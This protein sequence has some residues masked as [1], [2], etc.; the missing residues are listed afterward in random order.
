[1]VAIE[2]FAGAD[3]GDERLT[4][5]LLRIVEGLAPKP[6]ASLPDAAKDDAELEGT[7]RF[8]QNEKVTP[9]GIL[10]PHYA[11]TARR[12]HEAGVVL[13]AH[14]TTEFSYSTEREGMGRINDG[15]RGFFA[16]IAL[17]IQADEARSP[18]GV[19]GLLTHVRRGTPR[20]DK[21][22]D[23]VAPKE[24]E[25][26]RWTE[27]VDAVEGRLQGHAEAVHLL[28]S[29]ADAY[30]LLE[31]MI[32]DGVRFVVR[33][34]HK[35]AVTPAAGGDRLPLSDTLAFL[36]G[37][38]ERRVLLSSRVAPP[39]RPRNRNQARDARLAH[40]S[41]AA[42]RATLHRPTTEQAKT[43]SLVV[44]VVHVR[45]L[46]APE[47]AEPVDWTLY[48]T[49]PIATGE[50]IERVVDFYRARWRIEELFK[51]LKT[52]CSFEKRQLESMSTLLNALA[53]FLPIACD[54]LALRT[55]ATA[56]PKRPA[57]EVL[58]PMVLLLLQ[59]HP[60]TKLPVDASIHDAMLAVARFGGHIK[61]NGPP[62]WLVL[63]R[64][65]EEVL[66]LA[67]GL[68]IG[69]ALSPRCDQS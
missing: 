2:D 26:Y 24:R 10:A 35:R 34:T 30:L 40:L 12:A 48:T 47:G 39:G 69:L 54:L 28:D 23:R 32:Q 42:T 56:D 1:M 61:N 18:L 22:T 41:F 14:D 53:V 37:V 64:G 3:F 21:R 52:G 27:L 6:G 9:E 45:E 17:A 15:G 36:E 50:D 13:C 7:Y 60:R 63:G 11:A 59:R 55:L 19:I 20:R 25:S 8:L 5:R 4:K 51:A 58:P 16:H 65:Y 67:E 49:E 29:E 68:A 38:F 33:A 43:R 31:H 66:G 57:R 44:H 62:G 46:D